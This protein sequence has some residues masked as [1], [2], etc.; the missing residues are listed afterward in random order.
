MFYQKINKKFGR[1][2]ETLGLDCKRGGCC[3]CLRAFFPTQT[4]SK[5]KR[6]QKLGA[7]EVAVVPV[8]HPIVMKSGWVLP[9]RA[10][11][12]EREMSRKGLESQVCRLSGG[13]F[14]CSTTSDWRWSGRYPIRIKERINS[15]QAN[16]NQTLSS[17]L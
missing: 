7:G 13:C 17:V 5:R 14:G 3:L 6:E 4:Q 15:M 16:L 12:C 10:L 9:V 11:Q 2:G 1:A 8:G